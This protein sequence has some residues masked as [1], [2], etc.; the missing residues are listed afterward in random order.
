MIATSITMTNIY[1]LFSTGNA[2]LKILSAITLQYMKKST[3][4]AYLKI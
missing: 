4:N 2:Y 3:I 1:A